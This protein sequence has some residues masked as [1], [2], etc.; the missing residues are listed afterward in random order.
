MNRVGKTLRTG[1]E[2]AALH[3]DQFQEVLLLLF[4]EDTGHAQRPIEQILKKPLLVSP[5][6]LKKMMLNNLNDTYC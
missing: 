3:S 5:F 1:S 6:R 2:I 4:P